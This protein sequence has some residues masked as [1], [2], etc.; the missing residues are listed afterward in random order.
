MAIA[1]SFYL[2]PFPTVGFYETLIVI[3]TGFAIW[4]LRW[5]LE[6]YNKYKSGKAV[7]NFQFWAGGKQLT[8]GEITLPYLV[9]QI[10]REKNTEDYLHVDELFG[11]TVVVPCYNEERRLPSM[12]KE[13]IAYLS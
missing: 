7:R 12:L 2:P 10:G 11:L 3:T 9:R 1:S 6:P 4:F 13:H 8:H 5:F